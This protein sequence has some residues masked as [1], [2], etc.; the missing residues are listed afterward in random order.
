MA[1]AAPSGPGTG[2]DDASHQLHRLEEERRAL[3]ERVAQADRELRSAKAE[4]S[5]KDDYVSAVE[6]ELEETLGFLQAKT[7]YIESLPW[8]RLKMWLKGLRRRSA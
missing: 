5:V 2:T 4:L 7:A 3:T 8:V 6:S 1:D